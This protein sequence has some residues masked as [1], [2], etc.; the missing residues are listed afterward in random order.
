MRERNRLVLEEQR[1][2][3]IRRLETVDELLVTVEAT[4]PEVLRKR[5]DSRN[6]LNDWEV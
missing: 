6:V 3:V 2:G 5:L 4:Y 1:P